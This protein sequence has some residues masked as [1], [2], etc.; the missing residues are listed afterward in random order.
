[1]TSAFDGK[2]KRIVDQRPR[3][4]A[5]GGER[6]ERA[7]RIE[8]RQRLGAL[9]DRRALRDHRAGQLLENLQL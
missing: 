6:T 9:L 8:P 3:V 4:I 1:M 7:S 2:G 5:L